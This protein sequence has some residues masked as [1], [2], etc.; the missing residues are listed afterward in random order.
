MSSRKQEEKEYETRSSTR[1]L[2][3][4]DSVSTVNREKKIARRKWTPS[5]NLTGTK[6]EGEKEKQE[7]KDPMKT[8]KRRMKR[9]A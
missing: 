7:V 5:E 8:Q 9:K 6:E 1:K 4:S 2:R 3:E